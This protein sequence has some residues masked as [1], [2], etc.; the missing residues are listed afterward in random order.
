MDHSARRREPTIRRSAR[1]MPRCGRP[2]GSPEECPRLR[3]EVGASYGE[4]ASRGAVG[5]GK[6]RYERDLQG[7]LTLNT[8]GLP[9]DHPRDTGCESPEDAGLVDPANVEVVDVERD[10]NVDPLVVRREHVDG[11]LGRITRRE[12]RFGW[13]NDNVGRERWWERTFFAARRRHERRDDENP[14]ALCAPP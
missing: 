11:E 8:T 7:R 5:R 3:T 4:D 9:S 2:G 12:K 13:C 1:L 6:P 14:G 10:G